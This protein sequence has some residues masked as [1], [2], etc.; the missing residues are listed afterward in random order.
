[1]S[2]KRVN[3][4][5]WILVLGLLLIG[6]ALISLSLGS[7]KIP[8]EKI[9][10]AIFR[11]NSAIE[12]SIILNI[13]LP[14]ILLGF[15]VGSS[16]GL[17]GVI[18]QGM[19][20][21]PLVEPYTL[22]ISGAAALGVGLNI[23][24]GI[25]KIWGAASLPASGFMGAIL[26]T[27]VVY[28]LIAR[29][30]RAPT[31]NDLYWPATGVEEGNPNLQPEKGITYELGIEKE[32]SEFFKIELTYFRSD[33]DKLIK[34]QPDPAI[35]RPNNIDAATIQGMEQEVSISPL[36]YLDLKINYTYLQARDDKTHKFLTYQPK[37]KTSLV[38][39]YKGKAGLN[40]G[41]EGQF[42]DRSFDNAANSRYVQRY[43]VLGL[44]VAQK[45]NAKTN[46]FINLDN[47]LN[48]K[49]QIR[50]G[51]PLPGFSV[52]SGIKLEF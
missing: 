38:L 18:L 14:R 28:F 12:S 43:Y 13:R 40:V 49:Y 27:S 3:S 33:Y 50:R 35:F 30:F 2:K 5:I 45:L 22:G 1:M 16:L 42:V 11:R 24:L 34:W 9:I 47:L 10:E 29:S 19:F 37:H 26:V 44:K 7:A 17:S 51:Y 48:K 21:N 15:A 8:P 39:N 23:L 52:T 36:D 46:I 31:F 25:N 32:F 20:R 41:L 6:I 4:W